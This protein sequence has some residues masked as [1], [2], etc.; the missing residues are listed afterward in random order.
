MIFRIRV[1][2]K[3]HNLGF[4]PPRVRE[5]PFDRVGFDAVIDQHILG[6]NNPASFQ[7]PQAELHIFLPDIKRGIKPAQF[8]K[9]ISFHAHIAGHEPAVPIE[10]KP[11]RAATAIPDGQCLPD[12]SDTI[13]IFING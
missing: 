10:H 11:F 12:Q 4:I 6:K 2:F 5:K 9:D 7:R 1:T 13:L 8:L 3:N